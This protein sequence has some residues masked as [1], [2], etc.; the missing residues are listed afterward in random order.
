ME[1]DLLAER[2]RGGTFSRRRWGWLL[3]GDVSG[4]LFALIDGNTHTHTQ[5]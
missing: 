2:A 3:G 5:M 1:K 4:G